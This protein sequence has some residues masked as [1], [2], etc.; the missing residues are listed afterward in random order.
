MR[1]IAIINQKGGVGKTTTTVNIGAGLSRLNK[2][3]LI[4]D[5]DPQAHIATCL[6]PGNSTTK[7]VYSLI[8]ESADIKECIKPL[9]KNLDII[10]SSADLL[11]AE[12]WLLNQKAKESLL[13]KKLQSLT[14]YDYVLIDCPPSLGVLTTNALMFANEVFIPVSTDFLG[15]SGLKAVARLVQEINEEYDHNVRI[16]KIVPTMY[17]MRSKHSTQVLNE[18]KNEFYEL[19]SDPIRINTKLKEAPKSGK[20]IFSYDKN[21]RGAKDYQKVVNS[22]IYDEK[23]VKGDSDQSESALL[24]KLAAA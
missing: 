20:S 23:R 11:E 17:D 18:L 13:K 21:S 8:V 24:K 16:T 19:V 2:K 7:D 9:G 3:V 1:K 15:M 22:V 10:A 5:L 4:I 6:S 14:G 12:K